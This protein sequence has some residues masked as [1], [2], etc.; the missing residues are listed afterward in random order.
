MVQLQQTLTKIVNDK[1]IIYSCSTATIC[2]K[3]NSLVVN[4]SV[5]QPWLGSPCCVL[6]RLSQSPSLL[7]SG[8]CSWSQREGLLSPTACQIY[9]R[10]LPPVGFIQS[11]TV[12]LMRRQ[13]NPIMPHE[14]VLIEIELKCVFLRAVFLFRFIASSQIQSFSGPFIFLRLSTL[15][16]PDFPGSHRAKKHYRLVLF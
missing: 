13:S 15:P 14:T 9:T 3:S 6:G 5:S 2:C 4:W 10:N 1:N 8:S 11:R 7:I 12:L 16:R